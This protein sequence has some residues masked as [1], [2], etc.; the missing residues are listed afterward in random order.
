MHLVSLIADQ[1]Q[2]KQELFSDEGRIMES[3]VSSGYRLHEADAALTFMQ[4]L[5]ETT[6]DEPREYPLPPAGA[7]M[8]AMSTHERARFTMEAFG[9]ITKLAQLGIITTGQREDII[10]KALSL[11]SG[12]IEA[13]EVKSLVALSIFSDN[14][15]HDDLW[16]SAL[17]NSGTMWN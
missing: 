15:D 17:D 6:P 14:Q 5:T 1:V 7:G 3:L 11:R 10:E 8:R 4:S 13:G 16:S 12:R 2:N 9:F